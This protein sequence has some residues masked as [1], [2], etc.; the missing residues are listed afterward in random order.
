MVRTRMPCCA[1]SGRSPS[2]QQEYCSSTN[3][4]VNRLSSSRSSIIVRPS[5]VVALYPSSNCC[6][7]PPTRTSKNS[8]RLL[9]DIAR[10]F[11]RSKSGL[12][13][14]CAS[15]KTRQLKFSQDSSRLS[16]AVGLSTPG[17]IIKSDGMLQLFLG[18]YCS[19]FQN[20]KANLGPVGPFQKQAMSSH[21]SL[22]LHAGFP[23]YG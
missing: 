6:S 19:A 5:G 2:F 11:T 13:G 4:C 17:R 1:S 15:S 12:S 10:N 9:A 8:S 20:Y 23:E 3:S 22:N 16:K 14:S 7:N 21:P 18:G